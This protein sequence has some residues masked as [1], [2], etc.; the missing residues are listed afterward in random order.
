M[1]NWGEVKGSEKVEQE[2][3]WVRRSTPAGRRFEDQVVAVTGS[4]RGFGRLIALAL[5]GEGAHVVINYVHSEAK[6]NQVVA[7]IEEKGRKAIAVQADIGN[8]EQVRAMADTVWDEFGRCD[9][10]INNAG[11]TAPTKLSWRD[12]DPAIVDETFDIDVKGTMYCTHVFG[13]RMLDGQKAGSIV[14]IGSNVVTTGSPRA[15]EYGAAKYAILGLTK[16]YAL[17][18][19]PYV[20]VN[21][22]APG[23]M[24]TDSLN[25]R[26]DWSPERRRFVALAAPLKAIGKPE[27]LVPM[28][29]FLASDDAIFMTGNTL[30]S[31]GGFSMPGA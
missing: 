17:A 11:E 31:D 28:V 21:C 20:R 16:S 24:D 18:F 5:A 15:P 14:N 8:L 26:E 1:S 22:A 19:A 7:E 29:L 27:N 10:L 4:S 9:A 13:E 6:A 30:I 23:Y 25:A 2:I 12:L 3:D